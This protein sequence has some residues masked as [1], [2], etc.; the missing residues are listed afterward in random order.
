MNNKIMRRRSKYIRAEKKTNESEKNYY[1]TDFSRYKGFTRIMWLNTFRPKDAKA[2]FKKHDLM[3]FEYFKRAVH[4]NLKDK[5]K[6]E[7]LNKYAIFRLL[8]N[9]PDEKKYKLYYVEHKKKARKDMSTSVKELEAQ[10]NLLEG[11]G[12]VE[13]VRTLQAA[14]PDKYGLLS[15]EDMRKSAQTAKIVD[16]SENLKI[17][18][19]IAKNNEKVKT[20]KGFDMPAVKDSDKIAAVKVINEMMGYN[21]TPKEDN[22]QKQNLMHK[23]FANTETQ[24]ADILRQKLFSRIKSNAQEAQNAEVV[25]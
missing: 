3:L 20:E 18:I 15:L 1:E 22:M 13:D 10:S 17:L 9:L 2:Y 5:R 8:Y 11:K 7:V 24:T 16:F 23:L 6:L 4:F 14:E 19:D 25:E 21:Q 12:G